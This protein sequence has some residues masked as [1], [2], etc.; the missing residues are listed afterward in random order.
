MPW[1]H[2]LRKEIIRSIKF[3]FFSISAG[4]IQIISFSLLHELTSFEYWICYVIALLLSVIWNFTLNRRYTF[5]SA[6]NVTLAMF[7]ILGFYCVFTPATT[8]LGN[9]LADTLDWNEYVVTFINMFLNF[10]LEFLYD[11]LFVFRKSLDTN[12]VAQKSL[13]KQ[14]R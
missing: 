7:K 6:N 13:A 10:S 5:Q 14:G 3:L 8:L 1:N 12:E 4:I 11:R 9:Y 2:N